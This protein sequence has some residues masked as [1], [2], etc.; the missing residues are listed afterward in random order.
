MRSGTGRHKGW[1]AYSHFFVKGKSY[2]AFTWNLPVPAKRSVL[3]P[4]FEIICFCLSWRTFSR[5][6]FEVRHA[7]DVLTKKS[8]LDKSELRNTWSQ[9]EALTV[10]EPDGIPANA[11]QKS[12]FNAFYWN[13]LENKYLQTLPCG[14]K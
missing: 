3:V 4:Q 14:L 11:G 8:S 12:Q 13:D 1:Y 9:S 6:V 2:V 10:C 7:G 5:Q